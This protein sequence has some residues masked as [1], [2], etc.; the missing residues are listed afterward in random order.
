MLLGYRVNDV[1]LDFEAARREEIKDYVS[2]RFG[3]FHTCSIGS[4]GRL[5]LKSSIKDFARIKGLS[6]KHANIISKLIVEKSNI[7]YTWKDF[8]NFALKEPKLAEFMQNYSN[9]PHLMKF[10]LGQ[11]KSASI[12]ASAVIIVPKKDSEGNDVDIFNWMPIRKIDGKLVSEWEGK[13]TDRAGFLKEDIL[14]LSQL[15]KFKRIIELIKQN[16]PTKKRL[17]L[18]NIKFDDTKTYELFHKGFNEDV[19]QFTSPGLKAYSKSV[20]PDNI[21]ELTAMSALYRPG[22]MSSKAHIDFALIKQKK[23]KPSHD[24]MLQEITEKTGGL[25]IYQEQ[26]MKAVVVLGGFSLVDSDILR[27]QIKKFDR[28]G[29]AKGSEKFINGAIAKGCPPDEALKIWNK[30]VAFSGYG[31]NKSHSFAYSV[32][33]YWSQ[34]LKANFPLEFWTSALQ[35]SD[36]KDIPKSISEIKRLKQGISVRPPDINY[37][38]II[39]ECNK[40]TQ[41]IYW[42]LT[43]IKDVGAVAVAQIVIVRKNGPFKNYDD[44]IARVPKA[45]VNKR[46]VYN[47]ILSGAFD[48][49]ENLSKESDRR[50]LLT[51]HLSRFKEKLPEEYSEEAAMKN[52]WWIFKQRELTGFGIIDYKQMLV[53]VGDRLCNKMAM[54]YVEAE[55]FF[56]L[57][58]YTEV[59]ICGKVVFKVERNSKRGEFLVLNIMSNDDLLRVCVWND[60]Y[61]ENDEFFA[62]CMGA[63]IAITGKVKMDTWNEQNTLYSTDKTRIYEF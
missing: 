30:L 9:I 14:G 50:V 63:T 34:W 4:Y 6:F 32:M 29:M 45:K 58:D 31:F 28:E 55:K 43:K 48:E 18:E 8:I 15:D 60:I 27:T 35:F 10:V 2:R 49:V 3:E 52:Y 46:T 22:P 44:F 51:K 40:E 19:F 61:S 62:D 7:T 12:H 56:T 21:E 54:L 23:K 41:N 33:S 5:K 20:K 24:Y 25:Y 16:N 39:F 13:Y 17:I 11:S 59:C 42:S 1:D 47:L 36:D 37:S 26:I 38:G 57:K 53:K